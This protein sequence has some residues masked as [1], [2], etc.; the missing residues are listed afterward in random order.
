MFSAPQKILFSDQI[1][2]NERVGACVTCL[3]DRRTAYIILVGKPERKLRCKWE[4]N[5][6]MSRQEGRWELGLDCCDSG[7]G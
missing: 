4:D 1:K 2:N 5:I 6:K 7:E 3:G